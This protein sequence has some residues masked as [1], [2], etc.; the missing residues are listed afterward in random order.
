MCTISQLDF[1]Y[2]QATNLKH[3]TLR[4]IWCINKTLIMIP[5][6]S[7]ALHVLLLVVP[8]MTSSTWRRL[9][10]HASLRIN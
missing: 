6:C 7:V 2:V 9:I 3:V 1:L 4:M 8:L 10:E 5:L